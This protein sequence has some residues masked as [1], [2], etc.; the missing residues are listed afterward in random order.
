MTIN[1][2]Y[3]PTEDFLGTVDGSQYVINP[4]NVI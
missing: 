1:I 2:K 3:I 4:I